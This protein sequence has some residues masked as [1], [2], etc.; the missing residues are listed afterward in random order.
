MAFDEIQFPTDIS[1]G[2]RGG[3]RFNTDVVRI[4][5]GFEVRTAQWQDPLFEFNAKYGVKRNT[6]LQTVQN[7][8]MAVLGKTHGFRYKNFLDFVA[9]NQPTGTS[10]T[11]DGGAFDGVTPRNGSRQLQIRRLYSHALRNYVKDIRKP[12]AA[13]PIV[14][15]RLNTST[16]VVTTDY[17]LS[18]L[19]GVITLALT[20]SFQTNVISAIS[21]TTQPT[22][23]TITTSG[24]H[25]LS[26]GDI[27]WIEG[28]T[29]GPT[30]LNEKT[31]IVISVPTTTTFTLDTDG[32]SSFTGGTVYQFY[33][34][35][36]PAPGLG[37]DWTGQFDLPCR[38]N[39]DF[40]DVSLDAFDDGSI[41]NIPIVETRDFL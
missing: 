35:A 34:T 37:Y 20:Q 27:V 21:N 25:G 30:A 4:N 2:S 26:V 33:Q 31:W 29:A 22:D 5:S 18:T 3:P 6:Q 8:F 38:F 13:S 11:V 19:T 9:T 10:V 24:V 16:L 14:S 36:N 39:I 15:V 23:V 40:L 41:S 12:L 28:I 7:F 17:T 1:R 32:D